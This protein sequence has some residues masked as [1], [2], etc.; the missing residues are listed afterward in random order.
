MA[1]DFEVNDSLPEEGTNRTFVIAA[2]GIGGLLVLSMVCMALYVLVLAPR[3]SEA[4][5]ARQTEIALEN[6]QVAQQLTGTAQAAEA[7]ETPEPTD[8]PTAANTM[9]PTQVV[10][11]PT[12]TSTPTPFTSLATA[13]PLTLTAAALLTQQAAAATATETPT[14]LPTAGFADEVSLPGL[15]LL[16]AGLVIVVILSR[17]LRATTE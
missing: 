12:D 5:I 15:A 1:E 6:T 3:Q 4:R 17:R 10:V 8:T 16:A 7:T 14:A 13:A 9:T 2:A 11:L